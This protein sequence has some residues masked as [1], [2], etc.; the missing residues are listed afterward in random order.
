VP[1]DGYLRY[2]S[3]F[4]RAPEALVH[5]RVTVRADRD[6]VWITHRDAE[7]AATPQL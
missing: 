2:R 1:L 3:S 7:V 5:Q 6:S 4:H